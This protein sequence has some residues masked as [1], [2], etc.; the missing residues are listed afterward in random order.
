[1]FEF[2]DILSLHK[3]DTKETSEF[4]LLDKVARPHSSEGVLHAMGIFTDS[5]GSIL[6]PHRLILKRPEGAVIQVDSYDD[7]GNFQNNLACFNIWSRLRNTPLELIPD[8]WVAPQGY[9]AMT[10]LTAEGGE[11]FGK[12]EAYDIECG[13]FTRTPLT[14][15]LAEIPVE[16]IEKK[17]IDQAVVATKLGI[18]L[19]SDDPL[20]LYLKENKSFTVAPLD[21]TPIK[22]NCAHPYSTNMECAREFTRYIKTIQ[23]A[24]RTK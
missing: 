12:V 4:I 20:A 22:F 16:E 15:I 6:E 17:A 2:G 10:N 19:S 24:L 7:E 11:L 14:K 5:S 9:V 3:P 21:L 23:S 1:M 8:M 13:T 18:Q